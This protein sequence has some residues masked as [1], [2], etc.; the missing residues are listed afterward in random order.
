MAPDESLL[1]AI[2]NELEGQRV[3]L[4]PYRSDDAAAYWEAVEEARAHLALWLPWVHRFESFENA[5]AYVLRA[6]AQWILRDDLTMGIFDRGT[7]A[8]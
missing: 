6:E 5:R 3:R 2:P 1:L 8:P 7:L 4:R